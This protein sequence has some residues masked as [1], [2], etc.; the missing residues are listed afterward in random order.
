MPH[1]WVASDYIRSALDM[2]VYA[3]DADQTLVLAAGVPAAWL[4]G[5]GLS[6]RRLRTPYGPLSYSV[7]KAGGQV[8]IQVTGRAPPGG[9]ALPW[10]WDGPPGPATVN[11][12]PAT[13]K[14]GE[15]R[16]SALPA[17]IAIERP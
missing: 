13:W 4:D 15:L 8:R 5:E 14:D 7:K 6:V 2:F 11:G 17:R 1:A 9:F 16:F 10:P 12:K 3:R